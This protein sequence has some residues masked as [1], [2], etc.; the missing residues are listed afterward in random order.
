MGSIWK[1]SVVFHLR[2]HYLP[3]P[4]SRPPHRGERYAPIRGDGGACLVRPVTPQPG[5]DNVA[6]A[7]ALLQRGGHVLPPADTGLPAGGWA[8]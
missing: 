5:P 7:P 1:D 3:R 4:P 8:A 6:P 2:A